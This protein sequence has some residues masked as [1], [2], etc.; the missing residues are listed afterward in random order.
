MKIK[1][2]L[3]FCLLLT[4]FSCRK[5]ELAP[6]VYY[7]TLEIDFLSLPNTPD[8]DLKI[9]DKDAWGPLSPGISQKVL[10]ASD[11]GIKISAFLPGTDVPFADTTV[12]LSRESVTS[13]RI[14]YNESFDL[15]GW[16]NSPTSLDP[17]STNIVGIF[18]GLSTMIIPED[19]EIDA[20]LSITDF[21]GDIPFSVTIENFER[22]KLHYKNVMLLSSEAVVKKYGD[23]YLYLLRYK[24]RQTGQYI[25]DWYGLD[26]VIL[27]L[28]GG[29]STVI[30]MWD[31]FGF[32]AENIDL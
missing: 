29:K 31:D 4:F 24:D 32:I 21:Q 10:K 9:G 18:N 16:L 8:I 12:M 17:D 22:N 27:T 3:S 13:L 15:K 6:P 1:L 28:V 26:F 5:G 2:L 7:S 20:E 11:A 23:N 25:Y 19:A 14:A 30:K